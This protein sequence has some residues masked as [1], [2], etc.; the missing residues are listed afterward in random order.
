MS[1]LKKLSV[2]FAAC[3][4][5][6]QAGRAAGVDIDTEKERLQGTW[7]SVS[8]EGV[9]LPKDSKPVT[10][11]FKGDDVES[12]VGIETYTYE[13][14]LEVD[15]SPKQIDL[16]PRV[17]KVMRPE[18]TNH[19]LYR[20]DGAEL[21]ICLGGRRRPTGFELRPGTDDVLIKLKKQK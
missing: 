4:V 9:G 17:G 3:L 19:G 21:T 1:V 8:F 5:A 2:V 14:A 18:H 12:T 6:A 20:F 10:L 11:V 13:F 16:V 15:E 7:K